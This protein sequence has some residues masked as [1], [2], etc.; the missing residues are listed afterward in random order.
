VL[1]SYSSVRELV[2]AARS[3]RTPT[4]R[5]RNRV[6]RKLGRALT[7]VGL[8]AATGA[9]A[10]EN[11][12]RASWM[13]WAKWTAPVVLAISAATA[14]RLYTQFH[15]TEVAHHEAATAAL[16][17]A[18]PT[19]GA[20]AVCPPA[21][22]PADVPATDEPAPPPVVTQNATKPGPKTSSDRQRNQSRQIEAVD[23]LGDDAS[24]L[25]Q[26]YSAWRKGDATRA[27]ALATDHARRYPKSQLRSERDGLRALALCALD[28][29]SE[30][31]RVAKNLAVS[32]PTSPVLATLADSCVGR[33]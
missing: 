23:D 22:A 7:G 17:N 9:A 16:P 11:V 3:A 1:N 19:I 8:V 2:A 21:P 26:A 13:L 33:D 28:R 14:P 15:R 27:L 32:A 29:T 30:A 12:V 24:L 31:R 25:R 6:Y 5:D 18:N 4:P 20:P 10:G